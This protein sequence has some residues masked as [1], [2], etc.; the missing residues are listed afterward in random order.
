MKLYLSI[1]SLSQDESI[2]IPNGKIADG[3]T[4]NQIL[5]LRE[6]T[7]PPID[8]LINL[9]QNYALPV[10][11][12]LTADYIFQYI[13][14]RKDKRIQINNEIVKVNVIEIKQVIINIIQVKEEEGEG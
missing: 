8:F 13:K 2:S 6:I 9:A 12:A 4:I 3:I 1:R 10:A 7:N 14:D 5:T 11:A